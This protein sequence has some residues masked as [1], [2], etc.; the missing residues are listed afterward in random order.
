MT[1]CFV[2]LR[3][4]EAGTHGT[5]S[6]GGWD[7]LALVPAR[8][9][10]GR[11]RRL[12]GGALAAGVEPELAGQR[13]EVRSGRRRG[14]GKGDLREQAILETAWRLPATKPI[15]ER[16]GWS[17]HLPVDELAAGAEISGSSSGRSSPARWRG[18]HSLRGR[19]RARPGTVQV[20]ARERAGAARHGLGR[21]ARRGASPVPERHRGPAR[22]GRR[23]PFTCHR[24]PT[25]STLT[26]SGPKPVNSLTSNPH[27]AVQPAYPPPKSRQQRA[28]NQELVQRDRHLRPLSLARKR[29]RSSATSLP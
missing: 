6:T 24:A 26:D 11:G 1:T 16:L 8:W 2:L 12:H 21:G 4:V 23:C 28:T 13:R 22:G 27:S 19:G 18:G 14:L 5:P 7:G 15:G 9:R 17:G 29:S 3:L 20:W 25:P 10:P